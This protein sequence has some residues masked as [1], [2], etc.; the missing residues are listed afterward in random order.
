MKHVYN[1][2]MKQRCKNGDCY[3]YQVNGSNNV[4]F[5]RSSNSVVKVIYQSY[6]YINGPVRDNNSDIYKPVISLHKEYIKVL[7]IN[8]MYAIERILKHTNLFNAYYNPQLNWIRGGWMYTFLDGTK[9]VPYN[10]MKISYCG[11]IVNQPKKYIKETKQRIEEIRQI[12]NAR[13]RSR[14][15]NKQATSRY[16]NAVNLKTLKAD[17]SKLPM[18]DVFKLHNVSYRRDI[19]AYYGMDA[20]IASLKSKVIDK[21]TVDSNSYELVEVK[22]PDR[23]EATGYRRCNYLRMV[24]PSTDEIHFEGVANSI[25]RGFSNRSTSIKTVKSALA[26]RNGDIEGEYVKPLIIT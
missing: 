9:S 12:T 24:N 13:Q 11:N 18:D 14:Y 10:N 22:I 4:L 16:M 21:E 23:G 7:N 5:I 17:A 20:I 1:Q 2:L 25:N 15:H 8:H 19:I 6:N 26:W 3:L